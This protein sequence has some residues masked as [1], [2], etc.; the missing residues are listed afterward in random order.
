[1]NKNDVSILVVNGGTDP[2]E[3][4]WL[5]LFLKK[6]YE[7]SD[8]D[9]FQLLVWN[10]NFDEDINYLINEFQFT[11]IEPY[12]NDY[13]FHPHAVPLQR[14]FNIAIKK[15]KSKYIIVMDSDAFPIKKGWFE[16]LLGAIVD[17]KYVL[18]GVWRDELSKSIKPYIHPSCMCFSV[19]FVIENNLKLDY[20]EINNE[21]IKHDT[22]SSF[23]DKAE[24]LKLPVLKWRRTNKNNFHRLMGGI[25]G[26]YLYHH[27]AGS[28]K[29]IGFWDEEFTKENTKLNDKINQNSSRLLFENFDNYISWL[30][31]VE[32]DDFKEKLN[33][34][35][36]SESN[37]TKNN[38]FQILNKLKNKVKRF[39]NF[40]LKKNNKVN[41]SEEAIIFNN[42]QG[43]PTS[44]QIENLAKPSGWHIS[45]PDIIGLGVPKAGTSW[46][47]D[48]ILNHPHIVPHRF[49]KED[50]E[51]SKELNFFPHFGAT[52]ISK[53][54]KDTY[55]NCFLK[56]EG[57][58][59]AEFSTVYLHQIGS[60]N[61]LVETVREDTKYIIILRNPIDRYI[62]HI[63]HVMRNRAD[64]FDLNDLKKELFKKYSVIPEAFFYSL[65][66]EVIN[67]LFSKVN[68]TNVF[69]EL[70]ENI[71]DNPQESY[72]NFLSFMKLKKYPSPIID[73][74]KPKNKQEYIINKPNEKEREVIGQYF[75][76]DVNKLKLLLPNINFSVW[77]D[78]N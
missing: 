6:L 24:E 42:M 5:S 1:M 22:L 17:D 59:C 19:K 49:Y 44:T 63:N 14:L 58:L 60:L 48:I 74:D 23:T 56:Q 76:S 46:W 62:S 13:L 68:K 51:T 75:I 40:P 31:G 78:F 72:E 65:Y 3:G 29:N 7:F 32:N 70:Y 50:D 38:G 57:V 71:V 27:G 30:K 54:E 67:L 53:K 20:F 77:K 61:N 39:Y 26:D 52:Q 28:R 2:K 8:I 37:K 43:I 35:N 69:F 15:F 33:N 66:F 47:F 34:T 55:K 73:F 18:A 41:L 11:L 12:E 4:K 10:N 36:Q 9:K 64:Y 21:F 45:L 25:Y 16:E